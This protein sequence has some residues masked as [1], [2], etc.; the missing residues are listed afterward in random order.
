M[1]KY[2]AIILAAGRGKRLGDITKDLPKPLLEIN[3]KTL[4]SYAIDF[5]KNIGIQDIVVV[6]GYHFEQME[7]KIKEIDDKIKVVNNSDFHLQN[8]V[9]F[10]K[11]LDYIKN[12]NLLVCNADYIFKD[13]TTEAV[14]NNLSGKA[15]YCSYD[16]LG[17]DEDVMKVKI[18]ENKNLIRMSKQL[19]DFEAIYT[20]IWFFEKKYIPELKK[21]V[22]EILENNDKNFTIV[23]DI[24]NEFV[25][26]GFEI[27][28]VD[29]GKA[30][31]FEVDT[32]EEFEKA[33]Q[34]LEFN[35]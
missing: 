9:S 19:I 22:K 10:V 32:Q 23:E 24:F 25:K 27:K 6:A 17:N 14:K 4:I 29:I 7:K 12:E 21:I 13:T 35:A 8:L 31:W 33:K 2:K 11:G 5:V 34:I 28:A 20:G 1:E 26:R 18:D 16:L 15:A 3:N 30:D